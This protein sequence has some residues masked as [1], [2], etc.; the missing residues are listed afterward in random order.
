MDFSKIPKT[1]DPIVNLSWFIEWAAYNVGGDSPRRQGF[2][3]KL[4]AYLA[5]QNLDIVENDKT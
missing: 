1:D 2:E 4:R 5:D 3:K